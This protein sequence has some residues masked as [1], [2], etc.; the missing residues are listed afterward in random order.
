MSRNNAVLKKNESIEEITKKLKEI[1]AIK[2]FKIL[3]KSTIEVFDEVEAISNDLQ[4]DYNPLL[5]IEQSG[6]SDYDIAVKIYKMILRLEVNNSVIIG[7]F[8]YVDKLI[9]KHNKLIS[10]AC[11]YK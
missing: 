5:D 10:K 6:I 1:S 9:V 11:L 3:L 7:A 4:I 8:M 2:V